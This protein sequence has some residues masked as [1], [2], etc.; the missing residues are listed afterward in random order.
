MS[1][2]RQLKKNVNNITDELMIDS[3]TYGILFPEKKSDELSDII[4]DI[5]SFRTN[6]LD[7]INGVKNEALEPISKQYKA[8]QIKMEAEMKSII[9]RMQKLHS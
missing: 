1:S 6:T 8:I 5:L 3:F 4:T 2:T 7:A 9:D